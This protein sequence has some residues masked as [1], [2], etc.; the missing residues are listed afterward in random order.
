[1]RF[2]S[3]APRARRGCGRTAAISLRARWVQIAAVLPP[4][5]G[6][7]ET[8]GEQQAAGRADHR[9]RVQAPPEPTACV[10]SASTL[11]RYTPRCPV[12]GTA[13][14]SVGAPSGART[15]RRKR[16]FFRWSRLGRTRPCSVGGG[17]DRAHGS[18]PCS[19]GTH[20]VPCLGPSRPERRTP[21]DEVGS[22]VA[23]RA[24][25]AAGWRRARRKTLVHPFPFL[26]TNA[27][28]RRSIPLRS[29]WCDVRPHFVPS[30]PQTVRSCA[31]RRPSWLL[32]APHSFG[33]PGGEGGPH[34]LHP[35]GRASEVM[36]GRPHSRARRGST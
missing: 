32:A 25:G 24:D 12:V 6:R 34:H 22:N 8:A 2:R 18:Y 1:M 14:P 35:T 5:P 23:C 17:M 11:V 26:R 36:A 28:T 3:E 16:R 33:S 31:G 27:P 4:P 13:A 15:V 7:V 20:M 19:V 30:I 10:C 21:A 29:P 9:G